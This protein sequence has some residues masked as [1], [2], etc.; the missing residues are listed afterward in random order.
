MFQIVLERH[1]RKATNANRV[2]AIRP[3]KYIHTRDVS[4]TRSASP[5]EFNEQIGILN[6]NIPNGISVD[7]TTLIYAIQFELLTKCKYCTEQ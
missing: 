3:H 6:G 5:S 4:S 2:K 7:S 1:K